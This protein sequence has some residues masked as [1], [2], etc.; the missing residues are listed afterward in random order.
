MSY[1]SRKRYVGRSE[2]LKR[3]KSV[4]RLIFLFAVLAAVVWLLFNW[5]WIYDYTR[6]Y[7]MD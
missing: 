7:F 1:Q 3:H 2:K 5:R 4:Y 6:V